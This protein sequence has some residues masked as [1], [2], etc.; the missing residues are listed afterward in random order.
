MNVND[1]YKVDKK[2]LQVAL[3]QLSAMTKRHELAQ[4]EVERLRD[5]LEEIEQSTASTNIAEMC[6][7]AL[8]GEHVG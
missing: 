5:W 3:D 1:E 8:A 4:G 6:R 7:D 2:R